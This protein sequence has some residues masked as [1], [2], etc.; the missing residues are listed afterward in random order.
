[1]RAIAR[2]TES[3]PVHVSGKRLSGYAQS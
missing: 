1:V 3:R 2:A